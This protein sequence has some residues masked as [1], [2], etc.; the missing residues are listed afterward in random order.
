MNLIHLVLGQFVPALTGAA[1][2][3]QLWLLGGLLAVAMPCCSGEA[4]VTG[5]DDDCMSLGSAALHYSCLSGDF[6][7]SAV[8]GEVKPGCPLFDSVS[9]EASFTDSAGN[10]TSLDSY[11]AEDRTQFCSGG[12]SGSL[13]DGKGTFKLRVEVVQGGTTTVLKEFSSPVPPKS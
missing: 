8:C 2:R 12:A 3:T 13:G 1:V 5:T 11:S 4:T 6:N 10:V 9:V 7:I